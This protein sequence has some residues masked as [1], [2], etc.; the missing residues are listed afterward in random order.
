MASKTEDLLCAWGSF[1]LSNALA[2]K[3][4]EE[5]LGRDSPLSLDEY[6]MLL[7]ISRSKEG[8]V[9]FSALAS[10]MVFTRSGVTRVASRLEKKGFLE[11]Q[12]CPEDRR[13]AYAVLT[14][15]G[16]DAMHETWK[17]YSIEII[18]IFDPCFSQ[19]ELRQL[20]SLLEKLITSLRDE[21]LV[22][23]KSGA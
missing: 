7:G 14:K 22:Q 1:F 10:A 5:R 8:K 18:N 6:N 17:R 3:Q 12:Q 2:V 4:I 20:G 21:P 13:G 23:I 15:K 11:R 16:K 19:A 9:R